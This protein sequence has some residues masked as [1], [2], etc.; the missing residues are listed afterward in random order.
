LVAV[1]SESYLSARDGRGTRPCAKARRVANAPASWSTVALHRFGTRRRL[2]THAAMVHLLGLCL[3]ASRETFDNSRVL[4]KSI[5]P[6]VGNSRAGPQRRRT[7]RTPRRFATV[8]RMAN[9]PAS[10]STVALHRFSTRPHLLTQATEFRSF[11]LHL[12]ASRETLDNSCARRKS[13]YPLVGNSRA[14]PQRR[15]AGRTP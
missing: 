9:A 5:H 15:R 7:G 11:R 10:W 1:G 2:L 12:C 14:G 13:I 3:C 6:L 4:G 8:L